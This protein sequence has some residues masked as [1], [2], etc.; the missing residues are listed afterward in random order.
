MNSSQSLKQEACRL[1]FDFAGIVR[2]VKPTGFSRLNDWLSQGYHGEMHYLE[3]RRDVYQ[4]PKGVLPEVR[5]IM[6]LGMSYH[7]DSVSLPAQPGQGRIARYAWG[8]V[9]YHDLIHKKLK[10]L[11]KFARSTDEEISIRGV[12]DTA[13]L[14]EREFAQLSGMGWLA[15]NTMLINRELG[16]WF[17]IAAI[18]TDAELEPDAPM[19][20]DHC[21]TCTA[22]IEACPTD[23]FVAPGT[24]D[25]TKC[26]S[27]LTIEHRSPIPVEF[28]APMGDWILG[29]DICQDVCPW[30]NKAKLTTNAEFEPVAQLRPL[31]LHE[32]FHMDDDQFRARFRKTPLWRPKRR[33]IL[34]N[35][36]IAL[37]NLPTA[38][39]L[40]SLSIGINDD[41]PLI[42]GA[43]AWAIG[44]HIESFGG[45]DI[46][47][48]RK[49]L[50]TDL[51]VQSEIEAAIKSS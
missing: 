5:S 21:G 48:Q 30:N 19:E 10:A 50:E 25:A 37:G 12:V 43:S 4:H 15:K 47:Q 2:A 29:C 32:L 42:R 46:L 16:S 45:L 51:D 28:R 18:L 26:I 22:C 40:E 34:R 23:A 7:T 24:L 39:G 6:M 17:L 41:E 49:L 1:G 35:A 11:C 27:Y 13:P 31:E 9:D 36:A 44:K 14:L 3:T 38:E 8:S 33:G 20:V